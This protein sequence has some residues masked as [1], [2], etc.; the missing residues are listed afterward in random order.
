ML[1]GL[2]PVPRPSIQSHEVHVRLNQRR[3]ARERCRMRLD[4][5]GD[6]AGGTEADSALQ[7]GAGILPDCHYRAENG[8]VEAWPAR[9]VLR[10]LPDRPLRVGAAAQRAVRAGQA[11]IGRTELRKQGDGAF[12]RPN[13]VV[14]PA[15][16]GG[17]PSQPDEHG[18]FSCRY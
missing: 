2:R 1:F 14:M 6:V 16:G 12:E 7:G 10:V 18:R 9:A 13:R 4:R 8:I 11:V 17:D 15:L 5:P 3:V